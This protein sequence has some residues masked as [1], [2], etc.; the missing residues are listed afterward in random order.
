MITIRTTIKDIAAALGV[1]PKSVSKAMNGGDEVSEELRL[2][3]LET[4]KAMNYHPNRSAQALSRSEVRTVVI[5]PENPTEYF[6]FVT[7]GFKAAAAELAEL[8]CAVEF[9]M[10]SSPNAH[11]EV[12]SILAGIED[13][14]VRGI[15]IGGIVLVASYDTSGYADIISRI[16]RKSVPIIYCV[17][18][19][20]SVKPTGAVTLD[21][22]M[23]G[24]MAAEYLATAAGQGAV[25]AI[26]TGDRL[27]SVHSGCIDGFLRE[28]ALYELENAALLDTY[29]DRET[30]YRLT[31]ELMRAHPEVAGIYVTSYNGVG[32]CDALSDLGLADKVIVIGQD[33][34]PE[35]ADRLRSGAMNATLFQNQFEYAREGL[36][37]LYQYMIGERV[38][39][40][41][42]KSR[43][44]GLVLRCMI[45]NYPDYLKGNSK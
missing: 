32:V 15:S 18:K 23:A 20:D 40:D 34:Y 10:Y 9:R 8:R 43:A 45:D 33:I 35:I 25:T 11:D 12:K 3:V 14:L 16:I 41:C 30:A 38:S 22:V 21:S 36:R 37:C 4:A 13:E 1:S 19:C 27:S 29:E 44:P 2:K 42:F 6:S 28:S 5:A 17:M 39:K 7:E 31:K 26:M 24:R